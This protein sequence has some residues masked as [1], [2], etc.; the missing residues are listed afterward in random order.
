MRASRHVA[1]GALV[2]AAVVAL[3]SGAAFAEGFNFGPHGGIDGVMPKKSFTLSALQVHLAK[4]G[5]KGIGK[6]DG[7]MG[8]RTAR[9]LERF[10]GLPKTDVAGWYP[11]LV[12]GLQRFL[13]DNK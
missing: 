5:F 7:E 3:L 4:K 8:P 12:R 9:A 1:L 13:N 6:A 11:G 10:L 2:A